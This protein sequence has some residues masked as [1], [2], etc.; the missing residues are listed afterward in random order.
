MTLGEVG[1][2]DDDAIGVLEILLERRGTTST[3]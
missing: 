2:H 3:E 1:T